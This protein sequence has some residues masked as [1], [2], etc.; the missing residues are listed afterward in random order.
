M[1]EG[2]ALQ[3][4]DRVRAGRVLLYFLPAGARK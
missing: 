1:K 2:W 3:R 4:E